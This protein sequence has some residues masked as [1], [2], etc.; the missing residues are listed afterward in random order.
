MA[1]D[2]AKYKVLFGYAYN[3]DFDTDK[4]ERTAVEYGIENPLSKIPVFDIWAY[5]LNHIVK[6]DDYLKWAK[7]NEVFTETQFYISTSVESV[8]KYLL[9]DLNFEEQHTALSDTQFET[10]ILLECVRKGCDITRAEKLTG[11]FIPSGKVF[12]KTIVINGESH[13][14]T[15][16]RRKG[17]PDSEVVKYE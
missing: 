4:F 8:A 3:C 9:N 12:T 13:E 10:M 14:F 11:K 2:I 17:K 6:T 7:E 1:N 16:T 5:A 15:Y